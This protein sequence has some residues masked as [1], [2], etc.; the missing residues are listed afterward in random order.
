MRTFWFHPHNRR[1]VLLAL[2]TLFGLVLLGVVALAWRG[3]R[4]VGAAE[5]MPSGTAAPGV[6][7]PTEVDTPTPTETCTTEPSP[8]H[9]TEP[10]PPATMTPVPTATQTPAPPPTPS[11]TPWPTA[12][13]EPLPTPDGVLRTMRVPILMYHY[14]SAPPAGAG[15]V[16]QDLSVSPDRFGEHLRYLRDAGYTGISLYELVLALQTGYPLP[17]KPII[18]TLDDGYADAYTNAFPLLKEYGFTATIFVITERLDAQHPEYVSWDQVREMSSAGM[19]IEPHGYTHASL[20]N[21]S[22]DY[23]VWQT[24]GPKQAV[25]ERTGKPVR[26]FCYPS[27]AYDRRTVEVLQSAHYWA[28]VTTAFGAQHRSDRLYELDRLRVRGR[29]TATDLATV[30]AAAMNSLD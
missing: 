11:S 21:C 28:A 25:E 3:P 19:D 4:S 5:T 29:Y 14:I 8:P 7:T 18:I 22:V 16:R 9:T 1:I 6:W 24:L 23:L 2:L 13:P 26:L 17:E 12:T 30:I 20:R 27:G 15:A 10:T